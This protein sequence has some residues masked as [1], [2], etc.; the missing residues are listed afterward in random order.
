MTMQF[1]SLRIAM[2]ERWEPGFKDGIPRGEIEMEGEHGKVAVKLT[3]QQCRA[4]LSIVGQAA[5]D[6]TEEAVKAMTAEVFNLPTPAM[7]EA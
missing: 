1:K 4:I 6:T 3:G 5:K 2:P 7:I